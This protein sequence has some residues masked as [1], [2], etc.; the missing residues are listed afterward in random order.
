MFGATPQFLSRIAQ[1]GM[2][3]GK[4][5]NEAR[6]RVNELAPD[7]A[8]QEQPRWAQVLQGV[9]ATMQDVQ[10]ARD[11]GQGTAVDRFTQAQQ[12]MKAAR[13]DAQQRQR[14]FEQLRRSIPASDR[15]FWDAFALGGEEAALSVLQSRNGGRDPVA[16]SAGERLVDPTSGQTI[17]ENP[18]QQQLSGVAG[19]L[20][21]AG[22]SPQSPEGRRI[23]LENLSQSGMPPDV[24]DIAAQLTSK[25]LSGQ[26]L[27][28]S[29]ERAWQRVMEYRRGP[30]DPF[31]QWLNAGL[32]SEGGDGQ[33][34]SGSDEDAFSAIE[35]NLPGR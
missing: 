13:Q 25:V 21:A 7:E 20:Q 9:G 23:I 2:D 29:E 33:S 16:L 28:P 17:A 32:P 31:M 1:A 26:E 30:E 3:M 27:N 19:Q 12:R 5:E 24:D 14:R 10:A 34:G 35:R 22:V 18:A 11:G 6:S 4:R 15:Q 8:L